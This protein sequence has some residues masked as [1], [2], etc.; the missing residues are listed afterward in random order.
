MAEHLRVLLVLVHQRL[1][2]PHARVGVLPRLVFLG[3]DAGL[4]LQDRL[5]R[6]THLVRRHAGGHAHSLNARTD[7]GVSNRDE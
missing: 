5:E 7:R 6:R 2:L 3:A 4:S 1:G